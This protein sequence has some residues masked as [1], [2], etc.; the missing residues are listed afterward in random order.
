[1]AFVARGKA[2]L[3]IVYARPASSPLYWILAALAIDSDAR[4]RAF[5][6]SGVHFKQV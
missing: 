1:V 4:S 6:L 5:D 3:G 2:P